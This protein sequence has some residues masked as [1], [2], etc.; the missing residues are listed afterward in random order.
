MEAQAARMGYGVMICPE[1]MIREDLTLGKLAVLPITGFGTMAY[2]VMTPP[3]PVRAPVRA[4][5]DWLRRVLEGE[6]L[7]GQLT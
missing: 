5:I 7:S 2:Q 6:G 4:Y 3:G 1:V